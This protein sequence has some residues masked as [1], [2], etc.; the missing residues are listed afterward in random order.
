[1]ANHSGPKPCYDEDTGSSNFLQMKA[2][3]EKFGWS[4]QRGSHEIDTYDTARNRISHCARQD[5]SVPPAHGR[6]SAGSVPRGRRNGIVRGIHTTHRRS[7][8]FPQSR[9]ERSLIRLPLV[10]S[11]SSLWADRP[12]RRPARLCRTPPIARQRD[13]SRRIRPLFHAPKCPSL[14][15]Q[16]FLADQLD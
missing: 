4:D 14:V 6:A 12:M 5:D 13:G 9:P 15:L 10:G 3:S 11:L 16:L 2:S 1:M 8:P 7:D